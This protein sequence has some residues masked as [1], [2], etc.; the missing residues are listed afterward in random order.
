MKERIL[1]TLLLLLSLSHGVKAQYSGKNIFEPKDTIVSLKGVKVKVQTLDYAS[2]KSLENKYAK[3]HKPFVKITNL[4]EVKD[5][6][7]SSYNI[8]YQTRE[9]IYKNDTIRIYMLDSVERISVYKR[10]L[11]EDNDGFHA[12]FPKEKI[13]LYYG[14]HGSD[15]AFFIE[16]GEPAYN[17]IY[18]A[19]Q[20]GGKYRL[21][22]M[23]TGQ[24][25]VEGNIQKKDKKTGKYHTI[26]SIYELAKLLQINNWDYWKTSFWHK[27]TLYMCMGYGS[28]SDKEAE[29]WSQKNTFVAISLLN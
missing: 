21:A 22:G 4:K 14:E 26:F 2:F 27:N 11:S 24:E 16:T 5:L 9:N 1:L 29:E 12:Y 13:L 28:N 17:P 7:G 20:K 3:R 18:S 6:L 15:K 19:V 23:Y 8:L 25:W 10:D